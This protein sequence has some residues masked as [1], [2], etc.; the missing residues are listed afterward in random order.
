MA[1]SAS[2]SKY[3]IQVRSSN[4]VMDCKWGPLEKVGGG[5]SGE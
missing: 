3:C 5:Q 4:G 2:G 1:D